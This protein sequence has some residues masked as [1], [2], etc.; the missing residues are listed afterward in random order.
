MI[1]SRQA[2]RATADEMI[3]IC[4][5]CD[6]Q[7]GHLQYNK[8]KGCYHCFRCGA[9]GNRRDFHQLAYT[10]PPVTSQTQSNRHNPEV[11]LFDKALRPLPAY[12]SRH[13][14]LLTDYALT[15]GWSGRWEIAEHPSLPFRL[16]LPVR[17][18]GR[19]VFYQARTIRTKVKPKYSNPKKGDGW[20]GGSE[21]LYRQ[22]HED[23]DV[24]LCE[25][26]FDAW[27]ISSCRGFTGCATFGK[28][29]SAQQL[30]Q[31]CRI[32]QRPVVALDGDADP[33][34][35]C[36]RLWNRGLLARIASLKTD[37][38]DT[39]LEELEQALK[40]AKPWKITS[41][42]KKPPIYCA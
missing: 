13:Q 24:V 14:Q 2:V 25:G 18:N 23:G 20:L 42:C 37:P 9:S 1:R 27:A 35:L 17:Q 26:C 10:I 28:E 34:P 32:T 38:A 16:V 21:L 33:E 19:L 11:A 12:S 6:D 29:V 39:P 3:F 7:T 36:R 30:Q 15:R 8:K 5:F 31:I 41:A 40:E 22:E 4:C